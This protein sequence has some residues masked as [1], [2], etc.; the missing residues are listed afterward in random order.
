MPDVIV[1]GM[2]MPDTLCPVN[3]EAKDDTGKSGPQLMFNLGD[4]VRLRMTG[5]IVSYTLDKSG[6]C[7]VLE[8][9]D[10]K[11]KDLRVYMSTETLIASNAELEA[12]Q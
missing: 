10:S 11:Y 7:Y 2:E 3:R 9:S 5:K 4:T 6:D 12:A 8:L 1:R